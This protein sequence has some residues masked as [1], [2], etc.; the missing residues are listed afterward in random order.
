MIFCVLFTFH[1]ALLCK[2]PVVYAIPMFPAPGSPILR[3]K[4]AWIFGTLIDPVVGCSIAMPPCSV[5]CVVPLPKLRTIWSILYLQSNSIFFDAQFGCW[6]SWLH[7]TCVEIKVPNA[8]CRWT[9]PVSIEA[10]LHIVFRQL[11][12]MFRLVRSV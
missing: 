11:L 3:Y 6:P 9:L 12:W 7:S 5:P 1:I 10:L 4:A 8:I 2:V